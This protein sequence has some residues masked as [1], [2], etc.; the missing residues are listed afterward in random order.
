LK[1]LIIVQARMTSTR[2][3][4]KILKEVLGRPLLDF[5]FER[6][7]RVTRAEGAM[8]ATTTNATDEPVVEFCRT[9]GIRCFRGSEDDVL[10]RY[11]GAAKQEGAKAIVRVTSDCP[12]IDP[13]VV[14]RVIAAF[15]G[16][17]DYASNIL[18]RNYPRGL[19]CEIFSFRALDEAFREAK[20]T[21]EREH[22]TPFLYRH[23]ERYRLRSVRGETDLSGHRWTVDTPEDFQLVRNILESLYP[24][25]PLFTLP[26]ILALL[27]KHPDWVLLNAHV[28]Q[29][30]LS[31]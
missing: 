17:C 18:E 29:K 24:A 6:L 23:P 1:A 2:L 25:N 12:L 30:K 3:P 21:A 26:D 9:R 13:E 16:S 31:S 10:S 22:V 7:A 19:D 27:E 15:D 11:H 4:G 14:D 5:Q 28:E 20:E 8:I